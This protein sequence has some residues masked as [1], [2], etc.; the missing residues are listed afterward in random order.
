MQSGGGDIE[1]SHICMI[2]FRVGHLDHLSIAPFGSNTEKQR[3]VY[4]RTSG[5]QACIQ[6]S[7]TLY[8]GRGGKRACITR[9]K[10]MPGADLPKLR[11][12]AM[13][14]SLID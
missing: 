7:N 5:K 12:R 13:S 1:G 2:F 10:Q 9:D 6:R 4:T 14:T 8:T 3:N 11:N